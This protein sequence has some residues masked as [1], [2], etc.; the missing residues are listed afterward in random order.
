MQTVLDVAQGLLSEL[1]LDAVL[2]RVLDSAQGLT[3]ARYAAL[4]VL[5]DTKSE[6]ERFITRGVDE[7]TRRSIGALPRG[8]GVLGVL[9]EQPRPIRL[10]DIGLHPRSF[11]FPAGHPPMRSFLGAPVLVSGEPFGNLYLA[12]KR[13][14]AEFSEQDEQAVVMLAALA[15]LAIDHARRYTDTRSQ[16]D[17]L[18]RTVAALQATTEIAAVLAGETD[19]DLILELIAKRGRALVEA[20]TVIIELVDNGELLIAAGAGELRREL[21]GRRI[22]LAGTLAAH[23]MR[24]RCVHRLDD[25]LS[26][27]RFESRGLGRLGVT[28]EG[29]LAVPLIFK[30]QTCGVLLALDRIRRGPAFTAEDERLLEAFAASAATA[31]ATAQS[32]ATSAQRQRLA[33]AEQERRRWARELHDETLQSLGAMQIGLS[34]ATQANDPRL[35]EAA[36]AQ[37]ISL[38]QESIANLRALITDLRPA[39]LDELGIEAAIEA[40]GERMGRHGIDVHAKIDLADS[41]HRHS[42]ELEAAIYRIAQEALTNTA[43]HGNA[44][45]ARIEICER[46]ETIHLT[47]ED[48]GIGFDPAANHEGFGLHG[49]RERVQLLAGELLIDSTP[50]RGTTVEAQLPA[51]RTR[52]SKEPGPLSDDRTRPEQRPRSS[53]S[54]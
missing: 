46:A 7:Q 49:M 38:L 40:L 19:L 43:K 14:G 50:G 34:S 4:G 13:D 47:I 1:D 22:E 11:G 41:H 35:L 8:R 36:A 45:R 29:G 48:D 30:A 21:L 25:E 15:G 12:E 24:T 31:V 6:L 44:S 26:R 10:A 18:Q 5:N 23:A 42:D 54:I 27:S 28:A 2:E 17:E 9:I 32:V 39:A 37:T 33:A 53:A 52:A 20:R 51:R 3:G 16:R